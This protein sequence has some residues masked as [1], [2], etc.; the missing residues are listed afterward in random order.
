MLFLL[1]LSAAFDTI[2]HDMLVSRLRKYI[3]M[4]DTALNWFRSY[5]SQRQQSVLINGVKSKTVPLSCGVPKG[6]VLDPILL[7]FTSCL[8]LTS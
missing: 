6:S 8:L 2:D 1:D 3:G 7:Q 4:R 5:L